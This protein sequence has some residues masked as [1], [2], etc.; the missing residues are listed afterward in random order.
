MCAICELHIAFGVD[1]P[2]SLSVAVATRQAIDAGVIEPAVDPAARLWDRAAAV[3]LMHAMRARLEAVLDPRA[4]LALPAF[5]VLLVESRTWA[6]F[7]PTA[8]GFDPDC[9][10]EPPQAFA[11]PDPQ[12]DAV[13]LGSETA[14]HE[15]M[16]GRLPFARA[17]A[18]G[19]IEL[20]AAPPMASAVAAAWDRAYPSTGFSRFVCR[21]ADAS[22]RM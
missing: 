8:A 15:V 18:S 22:A 4:M 16:A 14:M 21:Q 12:R 2:S 3:E 9:R 6:F 17:L 11:S 13:L 5:F 10:R 20:D 19:I 1:H 7:S